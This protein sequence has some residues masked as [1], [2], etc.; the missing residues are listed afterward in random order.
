MA[1]QVE[2]LQRIAGDVRVEPNDA[3]RACRRSHKD[4]TRASQNTRGH[5]A[6]SAHLLGAS[7][8][9]RGTP[10]LLANTE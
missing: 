3:E 7:C 1:K 10:R 9:C 6:R 8:P 4:D 5:G 2:A